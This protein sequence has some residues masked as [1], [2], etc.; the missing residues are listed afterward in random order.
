MDL[1]GTLQVRFHFNGEFVQAGKKLHFVG[2]SVAMS[3]IDRD[4]VSLPEFLGHLKD[5]CTVEDGTLMHW[6]MPGRELS[7]GLRALVDDKACLDVN[8]LI[9]EGCVV[10]I[11]VEGSFTKDI[12]AAEGSDDDS[13]YEAESEEGSDE[14]EG[15]NEEEGSDEDASSDSEFAPGGDETSG[16][17]EEAKEILKKFK[18]FKK[19]LKSRQSAQLDDVFVDGPRNLTRDSTVI[20]DE[21]HVTPYGN[22]SDDEK[23]YDDLGSGDEVLTREDKFP[24]F[25]KKDAVPKFSLGMKFSGKKQFKK[26]IIK[27]GLAARKVIKFVKDE[28]DRVRAK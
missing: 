17:D 19:N 24:R 1:L 3:Y 4:K 12:T 26:A 8:H 16:G 23:S 2:G 7:N 5:H 14:E 21:G 27:Y 11:Y 9:D 15:S 13:A 18:E 6:Q 10:D 28:G 25:N 22:S 20:D